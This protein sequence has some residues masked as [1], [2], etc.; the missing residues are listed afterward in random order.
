[1]AS[2]LPLEEMPSGCR[3]PGYSGWAVLAAVVSVGRS[4]RS[5]GSD[6]CVRVR[7]SAR[8]CVRDRQHQP[9]VAAGLRR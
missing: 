2:I 6:R 4:D 8:V 7:V 9:V 3:R 1:M 5:D